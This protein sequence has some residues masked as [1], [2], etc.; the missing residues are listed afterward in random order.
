MHSLLKKL[1]LTAAL[2]LAGPA[3][4]GEAFIAGTHYA[5][6]DV[7]VATGLEETAPAQVEVVEVFSYMC[8][9]CYSF[10]PLLQRWEEDK[11]EGAAFSRLPAVFS[12][13]WALMARAFYTA[14]ILGVAEQMHG[15]LFQAIHVEPQNIR[16]EQVMAGL[17]NESAGVAEEAFSKAYNSFFVRSRVMQARSKSRAYGLNSV[18]TM[19]VNGKYR[20]DGRMAGSNQAMLDVV[21]FLVEREREA[22]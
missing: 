21:N 2:L 1:L 13:D 14:E 9:H 3:M 10:D 22:N 12:D 16:S 20:V 7:P 4:A 15:P 19:I 18:P 8:I 11:P 6:I 5:V 17:F